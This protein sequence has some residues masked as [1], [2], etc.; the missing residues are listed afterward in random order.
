MQL[1]TNV[2]DERS[3]MTTSVERQWLSY[4]EAQELAGIGRTKLWELLSSGCIKGAK[5]GRSVRIS[6]TSLE[7]YMQEQDYADAVRN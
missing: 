5:I 2:G 3:G 6:R 1:I 7:K 4:R